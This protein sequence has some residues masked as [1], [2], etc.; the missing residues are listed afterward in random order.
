M[1]QLSIPRVGRFTVLVGHAVSRGFGPLAALGGLRPQN[2]LDPALAA[3]RT[4][5]PEAFKGELWGRLDMSSRPST[6]WVL[7]R[8]SHLYAVLRLILYSRHSSE[9]FAPLHELY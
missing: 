7:Y 3:R 6:P 1:F 5:S 2:L 4:T 8:F 9:T